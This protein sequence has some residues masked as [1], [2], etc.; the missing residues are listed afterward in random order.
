MLSRV[1][2]PL[3][4][5]AIKS[6]LRF[7]QDVGVVV[8]SDGTLDA[9]SEAIISRHVPGCRIVPVSLAD[10]CDPDARPGFCPL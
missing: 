5:V 4:L 2:L 1:D 8:H 10:R 9:A 6:F 7:Y 3:Y